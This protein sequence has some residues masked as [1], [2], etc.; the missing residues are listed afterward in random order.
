MWATSA[1]RG[2]AVADST[3]AVDGRAR[4]AAGLLNLPAFDFTTRPTPG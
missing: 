3:Q 1:T 4:D 2:V